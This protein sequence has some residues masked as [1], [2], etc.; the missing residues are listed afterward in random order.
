MLFTAMTDARVIGQCL[1]AEAMIIK[2]LFTSLSPRT[3]TTNT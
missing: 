2:R 3:C 1:Q